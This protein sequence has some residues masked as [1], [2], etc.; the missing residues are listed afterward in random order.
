M[1]PS[2]PI[3]AFAELLVHM[4]A[5]TCSPAR[6]RSSAREPQLRP[7]RK[8]AWTIEPGTVADSHASGTLRFSGFTFDVM[9]SRCRVNALVGM[10]TL[11]CDLSKVCVEICELCAVHRLRLS[12]ARLR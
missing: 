2:N 6:L 11:S 5:S 10:V 7:H 4:L 1:D 9:T 12:I 3:Q 8:L